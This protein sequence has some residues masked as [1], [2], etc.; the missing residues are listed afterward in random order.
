MTLLSFLG[1]D[2]VTVDL[3]EL[4]DPPLGLTEEFRL[5]LLDAAFG[6]PSRTGN[7]DLDL[8][9]DCSVLVDFS[10][11]ALASSL[12]LFCIDSAKPFGNML[13]DILILLIYDQY[14]QF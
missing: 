8:L 4:L 14:F 11:N 10:L 6:F 7:S 1:D 3:D 5:L 13:L 2:S 12:D 9:L